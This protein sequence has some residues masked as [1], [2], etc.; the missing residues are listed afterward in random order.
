MKLMRRGELLVVMALVVRRRVGRY[1]GVETLR[2]MVKRF[3]SSL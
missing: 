1:T 2:C 3:L